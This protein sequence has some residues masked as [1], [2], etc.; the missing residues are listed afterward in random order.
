[1]QQWPAYLGYLTSFASIGVIRLNHH[2]AFARIGVVD[3]GLRAADLTLLFTT[4]ALPFPTG[5]ADTL[6]EAV[7]SDDSE[8]ISRPRRR[9]TANP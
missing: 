3:R 9:R 5:V 8:G 6:Q 1:M 7:T 2:Q 4:A